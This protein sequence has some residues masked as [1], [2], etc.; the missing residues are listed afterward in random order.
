MKIGF[1]G[2]EYFGYSQ[3]QGK[4]KPTS[5]HGGFGY[6]TRKKCENL[7]N[8]GHEVHV[9]IPAA[10]Y[11]RSDNIEKTFEQNSVQ[12]HLYKMVNLFDDSNYRRFI[13]QLWEGMQRIKSLERLLDQF[14]VD[15]YQSEE[16]YLYSYQAYK[17]SKNQVVVFQDPFDETDHRLMKKASVEYFSNLSGNK[18]QIESK[19]SSF[20]EGLK[21]FFGKM[22]D[23]TLHINPIRKML[24]NL[25]ESSVFSEAH[26]IS[27]KVKAMFNLDYTPSYLPNPQDVGKLRPEKKSDQPS[28]LWLGRW[29]TQKRPD[30]ALKVA[31]QLPQY[32][33]YFVGTAN[34]YSSYK[35]IQNKLRERYENYENIHILDF[36]S[37][38]EKQTLLEKSW[39]LLNT[40]T[41]EGLP[42]S[43]LE[44]GAHGMSIVSTVDPDNYSTSFGAFSDHA[45]L[46]SSVK[47]S[48]EEEWYKTKGKKAYE[49]MKNTHET[50]KV[51][52]Q[53]IGIYENLLNKT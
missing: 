24:K 9:F 21:S 15:V 53:H 25:P 6:L 50:K 19:S 40:S 14:P 44:A 22:G 51:M 8:M 34:D 11:S 42:I 23:K 4:V 43:F 37:E 32:D 20:S 3:V 5:A 47:K 48:L 26:F 10:S 1:L 18:E 29:D 35:K 31:K 30:V 52:D 17:K 27:D 2:I 16:P 41:R 7:A 38:E 45:N 28:V 36:V 33:F 49:H 12:I 39:T 46:T 13:L